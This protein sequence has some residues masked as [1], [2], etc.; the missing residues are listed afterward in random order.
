MRLGAGVYQRHRSVL[1]IAGGVVGAAGRAPFAE[2]LARGGDGRGWD[3]Q[4]AVSGY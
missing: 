4:D 1:N 3:G 2:R